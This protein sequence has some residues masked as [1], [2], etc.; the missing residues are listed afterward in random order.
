MED[1]TSPRPNRRDRK[2][3]TLVAAAKEVFF[4][5]GY[6]GASMDQIT[7]KAGVSKATIYA[8]FGSKEALL[9]AV[10]DEVLEPIRIAMA[11]LPRLQELDR[12]LMQVG[13]MASRQIMSPDLI[14]L[15]R[16]AIAEASRFPEIARALDE[17]GAEAA[18]RRVAPMLEAAMASG[19]LKRGDPE[20][21][22][23]HFFE[24]SF[25]KRLRDVL[26]GLAKVPNKDE[27]ERS[28]S[29]AV[30]IF[31]DGWRAPAREKSTPARQAPRSSRG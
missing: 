30:D 21:A 19:E 20:I 27:T 31:M 12:W 10:V 25:G 1:K 22:L 9:L 3:A 26:L 24:M 18:F 11:D 4:A 17:A 5:E 28:V 23:S 7:A 13:C 8:H 16:L 6:A 29:L 14:A 2:R 15:Q